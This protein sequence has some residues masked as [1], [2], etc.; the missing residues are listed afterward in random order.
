M[1]LIFYPRPDSENH[2]DENRYIKT[3][4]NATVDH[5]REYLAMRMQLDCEGRLGQD[6]VRTPNINLFPV[7]SIKNSE[8][9]FHFI[10]NSKALERVYFN[11]KD[12][13]I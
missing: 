5:L 4:E 10:K 2:A 3:T 9:C 6:T 7:I 1:E 8:Y 11:E 12:L 13:L